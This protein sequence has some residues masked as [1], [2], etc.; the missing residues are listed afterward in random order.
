ML[1]NEYDSKLLIC[2]D[3]S[4]LSSLIRFKLSRAGY[5]NCDV[6]EDGKKAKSLLQQNEYDLI[7]MDI[8]MPFVSGLELT[9]FLRVDQKRST[10]IIIVSAEGI[11]S[12]VLQS[13]HLG[14]S[15][16]ITKPFSPSELLV[17]VKKL[18]N[19]Y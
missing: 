2:E 6:A 12:T 10:P 15:D 18:L 1:M 5:K 3:N 13:F 14:V 17:R 11:E 16:F 19:H 7:V 9:T 4:A 8:H